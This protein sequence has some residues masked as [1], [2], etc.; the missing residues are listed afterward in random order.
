M[1]CIK[2]NQS[3]CIGCGACVALAPEYFEFDDNGLSTAKVEEVEDKDI[4]LVED[5]ASSCPV[6]AIEVSDI[7][8]VE[9]KEVQ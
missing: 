2:V 1:K 6:E 4:E 9:Y 3:A 5:A 7:I 8:D